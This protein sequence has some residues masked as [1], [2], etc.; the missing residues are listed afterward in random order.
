MLGFN[1][2]MV[3]KRQVILLSAIFFFVLVLL[4]EFSVGSGK[5]K[6]VVLVQSLRSKILN[7]VRIIFFSSSD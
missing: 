7:Y 4:L 1:I 5:E 3:F 6:S 2:V